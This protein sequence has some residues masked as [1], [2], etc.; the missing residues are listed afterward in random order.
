MPIKATGF[1]TSKKRLP[2]IES[3]RPEVQDSASFDLEWI[4]FKGVYQHNKT[5]VFAACFCTNWGERI[6]LHILR[7]S[8]NPNPEKALIQDIIFYL[9]QFPLTLG[10]YTTGV[11]IYDEKTGLRIKG[12]D[13]DFFILHQRC[14][15][16][17][18]RSPIEFTQYSKMSYLKIRLKNILTLTK[19]STKQS[20]KKEYLT[21]NIEPLT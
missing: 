13:S 8:G 20:F 9:N 6:I 12:R 10:W 19:S 11:A 14:I 17:G 1:A 2:R 7:Y 15:H 4:P 21:V 5:K 18:L 16:L 3:H